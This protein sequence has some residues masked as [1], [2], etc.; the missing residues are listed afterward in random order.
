MTEIRRLPKEPRGPRQRA[1]H[2]RARAE[3]PIL[4]GQ[5]TLTFRSYPKRVGVPCLLLVGPRR[6]PR[7]LRT[8]V[9]TE[10]VKATIRKGLITYHELTNLPTDPD[11]YARLDGFANHAEQIRYYQTETWGV[12]DEI[13][14]PEDISEGYVISWAD[15]T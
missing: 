5:K 3:A 2:F 8:V 12:D 15:P 1:S 7:R 13:I 6:N 10:V 4:S 14:M 9:P 11:A